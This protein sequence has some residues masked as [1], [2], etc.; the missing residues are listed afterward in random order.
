[1]DVLVLLVCPL[2]TWFAWNWIGDFA[3]VIPIVLVHFLLF[4]NVFRLRRSLE[5]LWGI[6]FVLNVCVWMMMGD[7]PWWLVL[8]AQTP[9][10]IALILVEMRSGKY[11][12]VGWR[13]INPQADQYVPPPRVGGSSH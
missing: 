8:A 9:I 7:V 13:W 6:A 12:G 10:T 3:L 1:M 11:H 5:L 4:C 2:L